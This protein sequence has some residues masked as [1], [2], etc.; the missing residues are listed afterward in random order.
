MNP[1]LHRLFVAA[2]VSTLAMSATACHGRKGAT[3]STHDKDK[4]VATNS[5]EHHDPKNSALQKKYATLL[6]VDEKHIR[7]TALYSFIDDWYGTPYAYGGKTKQGIDCSGLTCALY[8]EVYK[9]NLAG[10]A[11]SL[12]DQCQPVSVSDLRE[13]DLV[14]FKISGDRISH[15]GIYLQNNKF[16]HATTHKGVMINDLD[17]AYYKKYFYKAGRPKSRT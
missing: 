3:A 12:F 2:L 9:Q 5:T 7:N 6:G 14:F 4:P 11:S 13:G 17:E 1:A 15:V 16:V 10:S 8:R